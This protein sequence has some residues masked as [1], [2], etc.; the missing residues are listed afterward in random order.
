MALGNTSNYQ[1][2]IGHK[3]APDDLE[4][5]LQTHLQTV[6]IDPGKLVSFTSATSPVAAV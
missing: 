3:S 4:L 1:W 5:E 2:D 6:D